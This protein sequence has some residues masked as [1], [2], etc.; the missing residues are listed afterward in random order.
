MTNVNDE[1]QGELIGF[2]TDGRGHVS[3]EWNP[4]LTAEQRAL[5]ERR[6][7]ETAERRGRLQVHV[8]ID[9]YENGEAVPQVQVPAGSTIN[10]ANLAEVNAAV[11]KA[12]RAL[13]DWR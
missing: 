2:V 4:H 9:V 12:A 3:Q 6:L 8:V 1:Q 5:A 7:R 11:S 10:I 13:Q